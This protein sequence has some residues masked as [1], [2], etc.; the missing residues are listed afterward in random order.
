[1]DRTLIALAG[2]EWYIV[3]FD[4][5]V[6]VDYLLILPHHTIEGGALWKGID[7][8][9]NPTGRNSQMRKIYLRPRGGGVDQQDPDYDS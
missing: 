7:D 9:C 3:A 1:M 4:Y 8:G 2:A 6:V 5:A